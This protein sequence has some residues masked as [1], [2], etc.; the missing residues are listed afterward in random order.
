V[1]NIRGYQ[2]SRWIRIVVEKRKEF[3]NDG[4]EKPNVEM[5]ENIEP[6]VVE[7]TEAPEVDDED[8]IT[9]SGK[10]LNRQF[11]LYRRNFHTTHLSLASF[12]II[13]I[14]PSKAID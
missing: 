11:Q 1:A 9:K 6:D 7:S 10:V 3:E 8:G 14:H 13:G 5:V 4:D 2:F 12:R